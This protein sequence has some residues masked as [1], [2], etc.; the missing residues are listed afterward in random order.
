MIKKVLQIA[1]CV[2]GAVL[3]GFFANKLDTLLGIALFAV[4]VFILTVSAY[5][6]TKGDKNEKCDL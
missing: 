4:G 6:S 1:G 5:T 2:V 3:I